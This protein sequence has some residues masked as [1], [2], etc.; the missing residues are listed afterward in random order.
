MTQLVDIESIVVSE[1]IDK[2]RHQRNEPFNINKGENPYPGID[3]V[4]LAF[5]MICDSVALN[6]ATAQIQT[7]AL[8]VNA[9]IQEQ[10]IDQEGQLNFVMFKHSQLFHKKKWIEW[11]KFTHSWYQ[12]NNGHMPYG[13]KWTPQ[14]VHQ[15]ALFQMEAQNQ[16]TSAQRGLLENKINVAKQNAQILETQ[17]NSTVDESEQS[18]SQGA[19]LLQML[20]S[21]TNQICAI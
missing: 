2:L 16:E 21:L 6:H 11:S 1:G 10:M 12:N 20:V 7:K 8:Q 15:S 3:P 9:Q 13:Y 18:V 19:G 17:E 5:L 14:Q 4:E